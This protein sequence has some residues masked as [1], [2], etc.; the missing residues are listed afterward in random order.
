MA[1][2]ESAFYIEPIADMDI[3][4]AFRYII[5]HKLN[6]PPNSHLHNVR[7]VTLIPQSSKDI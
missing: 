4:A 1:L 7:S 5:S 3:N 2:I 6:A